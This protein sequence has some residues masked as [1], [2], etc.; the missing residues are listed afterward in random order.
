MVSSYPPRE[1]GIASFCYD[2]VDA[3]SQIFGESL[4]IEICALQNNDEPIAYGEEVSYV[5]NTTQPNQYQKIVDDINERSDIGM[6]GIQHEFG[7]YGG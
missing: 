6:I 1:C 5:L 4:P 3:M 2:M 7:L